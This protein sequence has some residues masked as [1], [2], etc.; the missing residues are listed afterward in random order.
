MSEKLLE[1]DFLNVDL[2]SIISKVNGGSTSSTTAAPTAEAEAASPA[3]NIDLEVL[4]ADWD[5]WK[6]LLITRLDNNKRATDNKK[7]P[8]S[9]IE[10]EFFEEFFRKNW[11]DSQ[12]AEQLISI[13]APLRKIIKVLGFNP[14]KVRGGNPILAFIRQEYVQTNLLKNKLLNADTFKAIYNAIAKKLVADSEFFNVNK[15]NIIYCLN[16]YK[17]TPREMEEYLTLQSTILKPSGYDASALERNRQVFLHIEA[18]TELDPEKRSELILNPK[19]KKKIVSSVVGATLNNIKLARIINGE[20]PTATSS[21]SVEQQDAVVSR[22][23]KLV[24]KYAAV[25]SLSLSTESEHAKKALSN[26]IFGR[27]PS[28]SQEVLQALIGLATKNILPKGKLNTN[29]AD[30]LTDKILASISANVSD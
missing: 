11:P 25:L 1:S 8:E 23:P 15:S 10:S 14:E 9:E 30:T 20:L 6:N 12:V 19:N 2:R 28:D 26:D 5:E 13:G 4:P 27:V 24:D 3:E 16:L 21:L 7:K 17:K 18:I 22:L 29:D